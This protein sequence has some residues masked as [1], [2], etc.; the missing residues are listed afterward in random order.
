MD[1]LG[2]QIGDFVE[3]KL[4]EEAMAESEARKAAVLRSALDCV[5]TM[6]GEGRIV[7]FNPAAERTLGYTAGEAVGRDLAELIIPPDLRERHRTALARYLATGEGPMLDRRVELRAMRRDG[8]EIP[9]ELTITSIAGEPPM[10]C[11]YIRDLS[12]RR[13]AEALQ[14]R[15]AAIVESSDDA[16]LS[17]DRDLIIRSWNA[18]AERLYGYTAAEAIG[19]RGLDVLFG[20]HGIGG[21]R[22]L[23]GHRSANSYV[24]SSSRGKLHAIGFAAGDLVQRCLQ[25]EQAVLVLRCQVL[26]A[27][28][29]GQCNFLAQSLHVQEPEDVPPPCLGLRRHRRR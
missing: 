18:G 21:D 26:R 27:R 23:R 19:Q 7:E 5:I 25:R 9:I 28:G 13:E 20:G 8:S 22:G 14:R 2:A 1:A 6:D 3:R 10:F 4:A 29:L 24:N 16:I 12:E 17:K 15:L 11:G